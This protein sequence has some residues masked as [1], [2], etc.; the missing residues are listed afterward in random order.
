M[1]DVELISEKSFSEIDTEIL[2]RFIEF[3]QALIDKDDVKL[4][5]ILTDKYE[6]VHMSGK[7]QTKEEFISEIMDGTL[8]YYRSEIIEPTVLW[9]DGQRATLVAD[10]RL[11]AKVYGIEGKWT[12]ETTVDFEKIDGKWYF[13]KWDN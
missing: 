1:S 8:N 7:K 3:Q 2:N 10:V 9:D 4:D 5:E 6:L 12:L 13:T 11:T